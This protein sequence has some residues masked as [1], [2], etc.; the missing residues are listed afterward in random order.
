ML[1]KIKTFIVDLESKCDL[2]I[3]VELHKQLAFYFAKKTSLTKEDY[4]FLEARFAERWSAIKMTPSDYTINP[5]RANF[6]W[7]NIAKELAVHVDKTYIKVLFPD[8]VN[9]EDPISLVPLKNTDN[10]DNLYLS[11]DGRILYRKF[12]LCE[13]L[14][15][16]RKLINS[17]KLKDC[18]ALS[19][20]RRVGSSEPLTLK[21]EELARLK[22]C[23]SA[24]EITIQEIKYSSFWDFLKI[25]V[26]SK[27]N[28]TNIISLPLMSS[29]LPLIKNYFIFKNVGLPYSEFRLQLN[30]FLRFL[31]KHEVGEINQFYGLNFDILGRK[32]YLLDFLMA[33]TETTD[34]TFDRDLAFL[35]NALYDLNPALLIKHPLV[36]S[37]YTRS[38][39]VPEPSVAQQCKLMLMSLFSE[40]CS[41]T[42]LDKTYITVCDQRHAV[43]NQAALVYEAFKPAL[44]LDDEAELIKK[45]EDFIKKGTKDLAGQ[46]SIVKAW[47]SVF[48]NPFDAWFIKIKQGNLHK[49]GLHW[50]DPKLI[51]QA[52]I[53]FE[54]A[55]LGIKRDVNVFLDDL[56]RT[57]CQVPPVS[58]FQKHM[59]INILFNQL[60]NNLRESEEYDQIITLLDLYATQEYRADFLANT[61]S[62]IGQRLKE[63]DG[64]SESAGSSTFFGASRRVELK[65]QIDDSISRVNQIIAKYRDEIEREPSLKSDSDRSDILLR[66]LSRIQRTMLSCD[67]EDDLESSAAIRV[68]PL[69]AST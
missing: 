64:V 5:N 52:L 48:A 43:T 54:C 33:L 23:K 65:A 27:T 25:Q 42:F 1:E 50:Y 39:V 58:H 29:F 3:D 56:I 16:Q 37:F 67:E 2:V 40:H 69:G 22:A 62:Y 26:L 68:D 15:E 61:A 19:T 9:I 47:H 12:G 57:Y 4:E 11:N 18:F 53:N 31:Y 17:G 36:S 63:I 55:N 8:V 45:Y 60:L 13:L 10:A 24:R 20:K 46:A 21:V 49:L 30:H 38:I 34:Y 51:I 35:M 44:L 32:Y 41:Y 14:L 7:V 59:R 28:A 6:L 66:Y